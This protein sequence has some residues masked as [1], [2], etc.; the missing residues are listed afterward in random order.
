M[1]SITLSPTQTLAETKA[2]SHAAPVNLPVYIYA[3]VFAS[4]CITV[5]LIWDISWHTSIGRDGLFSPPHLATYIGAVTSGIFSGY[6]VLRLTFA[7]STEEKQQSIKFWKVFY[8]SLGALFC[9]WGAFAMITSAPFDDWWHNTFGLDVQILSPPHT[10]LLLGMV[11]IQFGAMVSVIA[12]QNRQSAINTYSSKA[13]SWC[14]LLSSGFLLVMLFTI[15]SEYL[16][17]HDMH[18]SLFYK[19]SS[20]LF[21]LF[22]VAVSRAS[23]SKWGATHMAAVY[24]IVMALM[25]WIL[26]LF[27]AEPKLGPVFNHITNYQSF[28]FPLLLIFPALAIDWLNQRLQNQQPIVKA[29]ALGVSFTLILF[30]VQWPFGDFLSGPY[31]RN[32]FFGT[33]SWYFGSDPNFIFRY[34]FAPYKVDQG[35]VLIIGLTIACVFGV[36]SSWLGL[37]WGRWMKSVKR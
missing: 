28:H 2:V 31:A 25:V 19:V 26:P 30:A 10:V 34:D 14:F 16:T 29:L 22:L 4:F 35:P 36:L 20:G 5:G 32:W 11:T 21:P 6:Y 33:T 18:R 23:T 1:S 9:I 15:A 12:L 24:T 37:A 7:G 13:I 3:V 27:H 17:R 8:G